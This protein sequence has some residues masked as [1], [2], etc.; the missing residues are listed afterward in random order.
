MLILSFGY[1]R[2]ECTHSYRH[3]YLLPVLKLRHVQE[4][5]LGLEIF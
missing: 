2:I 4:N 3:T 5:R 1:H